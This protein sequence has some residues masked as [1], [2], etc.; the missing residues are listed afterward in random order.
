MCR[1]IRPLYNFA[2]AATD[3]EVRAA[4]SAVRAQGERFHQA[5]GGQRGPLEAAKVKARSAKR[6]AARESAI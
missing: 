3:E 6:F 1:N 2:P 4:V 5:V